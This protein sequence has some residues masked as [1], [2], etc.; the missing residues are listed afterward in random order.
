[1]NQQV[2]N[3]P[4]ETQREL[5]RMVSFL[6]DQAKEFGATQAEVDVGYGKWLIH[7]CAYGRNRNHR[8]SPR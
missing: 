4:I 2:V 8:V 3:D 6:L 7:H 5:D 1:M